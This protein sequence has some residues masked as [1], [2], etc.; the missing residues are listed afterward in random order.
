VQGVLV[1]DT[2]ILK[3]DVVFSE[4]LFDSDKKILLRVLKVRSGSETRSIKWSPSPKI[5]GPAGS[6]Y[7]PILTS[8]IMANTLGAQGRTLSL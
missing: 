5:L 6:D 1:I 4:R 2:K 3:K 7:P 8:W